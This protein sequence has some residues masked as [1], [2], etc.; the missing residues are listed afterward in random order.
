[1]KR[2]NQLNRVCIALVVWV[3][4]LVGVADSASAAPQL[5]RCGQPKAVVVLGM[6]PNPAERE[7]SKT[8][9]TVV[10]AISGATLPVIVWG[11]EDPHPKR[12]TRVYIGRSPAM[13]R[14]EV[15]D[16]HVPGG[17]YLIRME[18]RDILIVGD[19]RTFSRNPQWQMADLW[20]G[21]GTLHGVQALLRDTFDV[22]WIWPGD[23]GLVAPQH[24]T[25]AF[26]EPIQ[27]TYTP[28]IPHRYIHQNFYYGRNALY[29]EAMPWFSADLLTKMEREEAEWSRRVGLR[30][31]PSYWT[32]RGHA[33]THWWHRHRKQQPELFAR[34]P[35][36]VREPATGPGAVKLCVSQPKVWAQIYEEWASEDETTQQVSISGK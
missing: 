34:Q 2:V 20:D 23:T 26:R 31:N 29:R 15:Q 1:M 5:V 35:D 7:A 36:G 3:T 33:F 24:R 22:R 13:E 11:E 4:V 19:D 21:A 10:Q 18:K 25:L 30:R 28:S 12:W 8:L 32:R 27:R 6:H 14:F 16:T 9:I 17:G